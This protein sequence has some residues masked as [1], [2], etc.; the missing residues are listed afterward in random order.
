MK[1]AVRISVAVAVVTGIGVIVI[2]GLPRWLATPDSTFSGRSVEA[3]VAELQS[4]NPAGSNAAV[5]MATNV[6]VPQLLDTVHR[7]TRDPRLKLLLVET[8]DSLPGI[9]VD[10]VPADGRR[11][12][13][14]EDLAK[15]G[16][17]GASAVPELVHLLDENDERLVGHA[18]TALAA[19]RGKAAVAVPALLHA[20]RRPDGHGRP[21]VVDALAAYAAD[22]RVA[23]PDLVKLLDDL[24][25]K[26]IR[27]AAPRALKAIDPERFAN[28]PVR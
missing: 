10:F 26:E 9:H 5:G 8:L 23:I 18:A 22:A 14:L 25:S 24:G 17:A 6:I 16:A 12:L 4:G 2:A 7:D 15:L 21:E 20:L 19:V 11:A 27:V 13:A 28:L 3:W 1:A